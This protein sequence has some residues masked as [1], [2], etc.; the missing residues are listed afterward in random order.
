M[1][2]SEFPPN[3]RISAVVLQEVLRSLGREGT[4]RISSDE[5]EYD[6]ETVQRPTHA[7]RI[8]RRLPL[9]VAEL[10][11]EGFVL[12]PLIESPGE[13]WEEKVENV[14]QGINI[15]DTTTH[16]EEQLQQYYQLGS[17]LSQRGFNSVAKNY[18]KSHLLSHKHRDFCP[19]ARRVYR[20]YSVRGSW[21]IAGTVNISCY[22]LRHMSETDFAGVLL[23]E[24]EE[25]RIREQIELPYNSF[26][27]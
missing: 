27:S 21:N 26:S 4:L 9:F 1:D 10:R 24:A 19:T 13:S 12:V 23:P 5:I 11:R 18:A 8:H 6:E 16:N 17:L 14:C 15:I 22:S 25:A 2:L 3:V 7:E 20:L